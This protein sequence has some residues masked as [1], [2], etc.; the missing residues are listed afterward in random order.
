[1]VKTL[2]LNPE[3]AFAH[4]I[5]LKAKYDRIELS[6]VRCEEVETDGDMD[7][8][9]VSFGTMARVCR[10]SMD[11]LR[12]KGLKVGLIR[13]ISLYPFPLEEIRRAASRAKLVVSVELSMGQLVEDVDRAVRGQAPV[14]W[15]GKAGGLVPI[16][17][18]V[19]EAILGMV[20]G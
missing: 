1:M 10:T 19:T 7:V 5:K 9:I 17:D 15:Y 8:L 2:F 3:L 12:S 16:P 4:N 14:R 6:E 11:S 18:E 13:P 20:E